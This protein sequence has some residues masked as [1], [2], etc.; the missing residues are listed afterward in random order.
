MKLRWHALI[1]ATLALATSPAF[2][3]T[4]TFKEVDTFGDNPGELRMFTYVPA[5]LPTDKPVP[6]V[7]ALHGCLQT[8]E[9]FY[10]ATGWAE[11]A[12]EKKFI[13][14][15]PQ[16]PSTV[17]AL[18]CFD[19][20]EPVNQKAGDGEPLSIKNMISTVTKHLYP[21][22]IDEKAIYVT[23]LSAGA[24][25][26]GTM[27]AAYP[28]VFAGGAIV[29]GPPYHCADDLMSGNICMGPAHPDLTPDQWGKLVRNAGTAPGALRK[30][31]IW[32]GSDDAVV[33]PGNLKED[34]EQWTNVFGVSQQPVVSTQV[35]S[36][37]KNNTNSQNQH[38]DTVSSSSL[39]LTTYL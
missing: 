14:L 19:W 10:K 20:Y 3:L 12:D 11:L 4:G 23:G 26:T 36:A 21:K 7:V 37:V 9:D 2:A 6:L 27:M 32:I 35:A 17:N 15:L 33:D 1:A 34:M 25:M 31:S 28:Q 38:K 18:S 16:Q 29:A 39:I 13:L 5:Q 22:R 8:A 24:A 30:V